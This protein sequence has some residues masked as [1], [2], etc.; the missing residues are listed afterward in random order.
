MTKYYFDKEADDRAVSFIEKFITHTKGELAGKP[1]L[2]EG[3]QKEIVEKIFGWKIGAIREDFQDVMIGHWHTPT[4]MTFNTVQ[5][6]VA[7]S[8]E[9]CNDYAAEKLGAV[10][11]ASQHLQFVHPEKGIVT[12]EYTVWLDE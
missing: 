10:G 11:R 8:S 3:W 4:K 9:S 1:L 2:L 5:C 12:A 7:G 6:R